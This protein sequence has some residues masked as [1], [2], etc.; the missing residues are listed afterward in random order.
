MSSNPGQ[1]YRRSAAQLRNI[2]AQKRKV[3]GGRFIS[4][5]ALASPSRSWWVVKDDQAFVAAYV[6]EVPRMTATTTTYK[7]A[8]DDGM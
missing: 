1:D 6:K 2:E 3:I 5:K 8:Y 4:P 7:F